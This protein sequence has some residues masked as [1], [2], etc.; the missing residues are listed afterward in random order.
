MSSV[1][2]RYEQSYSFTKKGIKHTIREKVIDGPS[3]MSLVY[4][5]KTGDE[6]YKIYVKEESKDK[7][8]FKEKI[9]E[10]ETEKDISEKELMALLKKNKLDSIIEFIVKERGTYKGKKVSKKPI[11]LS[12]M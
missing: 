11:K 1:T 9:G 6:F 3:G 12:S 4:L 5:K 8:L 10:K 7:Y 2:Y